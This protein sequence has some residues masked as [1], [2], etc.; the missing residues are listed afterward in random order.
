LEYLA[1]A[2]ATGI[3]PETSISNYQHSLHNNPEERTPNR[4]TEWAEFVR[5]THVLVSVSLPKETLVVKANAVILSIH[6]T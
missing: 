3:L 4:R 6:S 5:L 2:N 1:P